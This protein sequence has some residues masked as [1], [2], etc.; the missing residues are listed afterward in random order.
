MPAGG[1]NRID[2]TGQRFG[3]LVVQHALGRVGRQLA[4][5]CLCDCGKSCSYRG[6]YLRAGSAK[7]CGCRIGRVRSTRT[8]PGFG[9]IAR[10]H[11]TSLLLNAQCRNICDDITPQF[12]WELFVTQGRACALSGVLL[13]MYPNKIRTASLDR[14]NS[15]LGYTVGNVQ[16][17]HKT[18]NTMK[19][20]FDQTQ[21]ID[22]CVKV[23]EHVSS[24][25]Q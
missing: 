14:V 13:T 8:R 1:Q 24:R 5:E 15:S 3:S 4:W 20:A 11:W 6:S 10:S 21:F 12:A 23:A 17:V 22:W 2:L 25:S 18:L 16:W 19:M 7:T 9:E